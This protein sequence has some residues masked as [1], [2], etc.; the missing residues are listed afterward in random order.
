M[1]S[2]VQ[3]Y[4]GAE[5]DHRGRFLRDVIAWPDERLESVHDFIQWLFPLPD[6][7]PVNPHAPLL[8]RET[9]EAFAA[10]AN[11]RDA[12]RTSLERM[13]KFYGFALGPGPMV[14][15]TKQFA[16][17]AENWL[18]PGNHNHLRITRILKCLS[19]LGLKA[20][21]AAFEG[22][23]ETVYAEHRDRITAATIR[24]WRRASNF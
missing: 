5:P 3:F 7:S 22:A 15:R 23:L 10:R 19:I 12:L 2:I 20:E 16:A 17:R 18:W 14:D 6:P 9:V 24:F 4:S 1:P 13:L 21:A 8:N 11:L